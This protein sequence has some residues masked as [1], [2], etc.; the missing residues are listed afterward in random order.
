MA[1]REE[2]AARDSGLVRGSCRAATIED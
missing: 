2:Q 1:L